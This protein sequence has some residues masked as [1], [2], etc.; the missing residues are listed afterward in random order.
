MENGTPQTTD[1]KQRLENDLA[2]KFSLFQTIKFLEASEHALIELMDANKIWIGP[3]PANPG[4]S[5]D[6]EWG[7]IPYWV[8]NPPAFILTYIESNDILKDAWKVLEFLLPARIDTA[9][10]NALVNQVVHGGLVA[11]D[12]TIFGDGQY[13]QIDPRWLFSLADYLIV[14]TT[15]DMAPFS[16]KQVLPIALKDNQGQVK[17]ALVGDWGTGSFIDGEAI[18]VMTQIMGLSPDY[19][20]HLGDVY[21]AGTNADFLPVDEEMNNFLND[22]PNSS[23]LPA[24]NSFMLNSNHEMYSG[25]K[26][27]FNVGLAD[28]RFSQ[29]LGTS[30]FALQYAGWTILGLDSAYYSS[31][32]MF[33]SGS[34]GTNGVQSGWIQGLRSNGQPLSPNKVIVM[35]HH[36]ALSYDGLAEDTTYWNQITSALNGDPAAW[37]WGHA[38]DGVAYKSPT[39]T[40]RTTLAR[41]VGHGAVP[42][43]DAFGCASSSQVDYYSHTP[44]P[45]PP[46]VY[47]GFVLLTIA[48]SG[49]ITEEFY[50]QGSTIAKFTRQY[51]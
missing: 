29:Q 51:G 47:N 12:G 36:N 22:W 11:A 44:A 15:G 45:N 13:E 21:Y 31:S 40:Q 35:T 42:Y 1:L 26:G 10:Y 46:R 14:V 28:N 4:G 3:V 32:A 8:N 5:G 34:L 19:L 2:L 17:I 49:V 33:M 16:N 25:A 18:N 30:Y 39:V 9:N 41:C 23:Q 50:E 7:L 38:H 20:I 43:G 27:Y 48:A 6:I 37:Y 24:G